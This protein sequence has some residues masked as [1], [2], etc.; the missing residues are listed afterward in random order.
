MH[1]SASISTKWQVVFP[2]K[3]ERIDA[4]LKVKKCL[5][6]RK[7]AQKGLKEPENRVPQLI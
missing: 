5:K 7:K 4:V 3:R 6:C 1:T 2:L